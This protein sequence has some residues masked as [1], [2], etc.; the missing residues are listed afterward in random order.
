MF[1]VRNSPS[2][3]KYFQINYLRV[4]SHF[5][6]LLLLLLL[7]MPFQYR[8]F[9]H[10]RDTK[11]A[12]IKSQISCCESWS[13]HQMKI[14]IV[15]DIVYRTSARNSKIR[16]S[17]TTTSGGDNDDPMEMGCDDIIW[18][19]K[20]MKMTLFIVVNCNQINAV[21]TNDSMCLNYVTIHTWTIRN[22]KQNSK[23]LLSSIAAT[24]L[25]FA[26]PTAQVKFKHQTPWKRDMRFIFLYT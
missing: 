9:A 11:N 22:S 15:V 24:K 19:F 3:F 14:F 4:I 18:K 7:F 2:R 23:D 16:T 1:W 26:S 21:V 5:H 25:Q 10:K 13:Q 8:I 6:P 20:V 17:Q 12:W